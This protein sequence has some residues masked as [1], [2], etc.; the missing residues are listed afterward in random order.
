MVEPVQ[1]IRN[2]KSQPNGNESVVELPQGLCPGSRRFQGVVAEV[3][4]RALLRV[5][6]MG[7]PGMLLMR[8]LSV[9]VIMAGELTRRM[10]L[11]RHANSRQSNPSVRVATESLLA[12]PIATSL[13]I[14]LIRICAV[15]GKPYAA[16]YFQ[17]EFVGTLRITTA[18]YRSNY[19]DNGNGG[20]VDASAIAEETCMWCGL[21]G[22]G[23]VWC[24]SCRRESCYGLT[25]HKR[26]KCWCGFEA[27]IV[28]VPRKHG[29]LIVGCR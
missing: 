15:T 27:D 2:T 22:H 20:I 4:V 3:S 17:N 18:L 7:V 9:E 14:D 12:Q 6:K 8:E 21:S 5:P 19:E 23:A 13:P 1:R 26:F 10:E 24:G 29:G 11:L 16:R 28:S 25:R